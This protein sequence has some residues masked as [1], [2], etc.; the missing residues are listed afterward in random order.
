MPLLAVLSIGA[1]AAPSL[2]V[3]AKTGETPG[4][5]CVAETTG[6]VNAAEADG[7]TALHWAV[8]RDN[9]EAVVTCS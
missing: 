6:Y 7:T 9:L 4:S 8:H 1:A 3:A 2:L 5:A